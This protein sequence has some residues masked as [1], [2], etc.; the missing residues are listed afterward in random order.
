[1]SRW[2]GFGSLLPLVMLA[3]A[4]CGPTNHYEVELTPQGKSLKR[5]ITAWRGNADKPED[6]PAFPQ[7]ELAKLARAYNAQIPEKLNQKHKFAAVFAGEMPEDVGGK[8]SFI[9]WETSLGTMSAYVE[10][11]RG[12]DDLVADVDSRM[13]LCDQFAQQLTGWLESELKNEPGFSELKKFLDGDFRRDLK[14]LSLLSWTFYNIE[15]IQGPDP[16]HSVLQE[17][18]VIRAG[19][20]LIERSYF[21][22]EEL[23]M[24][25]RSFSDSD[26]KDPERLLEFIQR[27]I[28]RKMG[29]GEDKPIPKG[30]RFLRSLEALEASFNSY[31]RETKEYQQLLEEWEKKKAANPEARRPEPAEVLILPLNPVP[32][33]RFP[34]DSLELTLAVPVKPTSTNGQWDAKKKQVRWTRRLLEADSE[35]TEFPALCYAI[36]S[37]PNAKAQTERFGEVILEGQPLARY[38]L[39]HRGLSDAEAKEWETFLASLKPGKELAG[40][41]RGFRFSQEPAAQ[42]GENLK[43][44]AAQ[45]C[46][47]LL[48]GLGDDVK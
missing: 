39:W 46:R 18:F 26:N 6:M 38:C 1:M 9:H 28:A 24:V 15:R 25:L 21:T 33:L 32:F 29:I 35:G 11:F 14:N 19:Q 8:G 34:S 42:Q 22:V 7:E 2:F 12:S 37:E 40:R 20:Y 41:L 4:G 48:E 23:P 16:T 30:L 13:K 5:E 45:P 17:E 47:L 43:G 10:R 31:F 27:R 3:S 36:W 44:L